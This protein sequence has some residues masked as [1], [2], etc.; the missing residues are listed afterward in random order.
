[1]SRK[2][3][4]VLALIALLIGCKSEELPRTSMSTTLHAPQKTFPVR[5]KVI[6][7]D[8]THV[9][10][11]HEAVPGFMDAMTMPYKLKD[12][13]VVSELHPGDL[14][15]A[16]ILATADGTEFHDVLL[17]NIVVIAQARPDYK[18]AVQYHVPQPGDTVPNFA[19]LNQSDRTL[20]L[21]Q[22]KGKVLVATFVYTRCPLADYCPRMSR[23]FAEID[24][25]LQTDPDL[26]AK[27]HLLSISFDPTY[28]TPKV[29]RS[30]GGAYTGNY[31]TET[32]KHWDFAAPSEKD[33]PAVTQFFNVGI[34]P[35]D[36]KTL[37]HSLST[38]IIGKDGKVAAWYPTN[39]WQPA[40]LVAQIKKL[41]A[42]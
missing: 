17:D 5:G 33:L 16:T 20:H 38:I 28:D 1:V 18:P 37:T 25:A 31:T 36:A 23:N 13:S 21:S 32:F 27:T 24:K 26:Y 22:F 9:T 7:T 3:L 4:L 19:L 30:Y 10:L 39:D 14:I 2:P 6:A 15:T 35:G 29:L 41:A 40:D 12:P 42:S 34:T 8:A 11:D